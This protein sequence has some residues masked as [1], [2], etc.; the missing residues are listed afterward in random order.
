MKKKLALFGRRGFVGGVLVALGA[1]GGTL[2]RAFQSPS[3]IRKPRPTTKTSSFVYDVSEWEVTDRSLLLYE[4]ER[5]FETGFKRSKRIAVHGDKVFIAGDRSIKVFSSS[6]SMESEIKLSRPPHCLHITQEKELFV[7]LGNYFEVYNFAGERQL[8]SPRPKGD[9]T[10]LT[11]IAVHEDTVYL[12]DGGMR[13]VVLCD[14]KTGV[15][16]GRFGKKDEGLNNPGIVVPSP[17]FDLMVSGVGEIC[18]ANTGR[19]RMETYSLDGRFKATWGGPGM[20]VDKFCGC[21]NPVYFTL[22][23]NGDTI[24]SEKGLARINVYGPDGKFKGAV[25]G[26]DMLVEDKALAKQACNDC[27]VGAGFDIAID[28]SGRILALDPFRMVVR[29][30]KP[31]DKAA[32]SAQA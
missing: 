5:E 30:F 13:E 14:R 17:Y 10:F 28:G 12:A 24:T 21:C 15:E 19:L 26:P 27:S 20:A 4:P 2:V 18:L 29:V 6:G 22:A 8:K 9:S 31:I 25:A 11:A 1:I 7:G 16:K 23:P 32:P 3:A